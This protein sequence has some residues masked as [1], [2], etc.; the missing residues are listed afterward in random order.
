MSPLQ[1][2]LISAFLVLSIVQAEQI[3]D[4][5][6]ENDELTSN[7]EKESDPT[8]IDR[9]KKSTNEAAVSFCD[10]ETLKWF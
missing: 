5:D 10:L 1:A 8:D 6:N 2:V 3:I 4:I 9:F 7:V